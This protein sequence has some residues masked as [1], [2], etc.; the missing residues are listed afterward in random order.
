VDRDAHQLARTL[1]GDLDP[2]AR[3]IAV[4]GGGWAGLAAAVE[5]TSRGHHV[6][7]FEMASQLG[8]RARRVEVEG[9]S[10]DNGQHILIGAYSHTLALLGRVGVDVEGALRRSPLSLVAPDGRGLVLLPGRPAVAFVRAVAA[11]P[12]WSAWDRLTLLAVV[13][14]WAARRFRCPE[15]WTVEHLCRRLTP[16]VR[17]ELVGPLCVAALNTPPSQASA[18]VFLQVLRDALFAGRGSSDLLLPRRDLGALLPDPAAAWLQCHG[19]TL[20]LGW[21]VGCL[22]RCAGHWEVDDDAPFD[23]VVLATPPGEA[24]RLVREHAPAWAASAEALRHQP[25][26]TVYVEAEGAHL[27]EPMLALAGDD[28]HAPAQF[29]FDL[30]ALRGHAGVLAFV[31]SGAQRWVERGSGAIEQAILQQA[32]RELGDR[33][34][35]AARPLRTISERRATFACEPALRRPPTAIAPGLVAAGDHVAGPYPATLE[36]AV[37]SGIA[38]VDALPR[39]LSAMQNSVPKTALR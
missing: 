18:A 15:D 25:I 2:G 8:G 17:R 31:V 7:L 22:R 35:E 29:V 32:R 21:R 27:P 11:H 14:R 5:A 23:A 36:G 16:A 19:A 9:R 10:L 39:R 30:G 37:R 13:A 3:R 28:D 26:V 24:A 1:S 12:R 38:A 33:L 20:R 4:V 34:G 6:T